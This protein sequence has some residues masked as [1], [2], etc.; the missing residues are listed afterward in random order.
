[1]NPV[2]ADSVSHAICLL[3]FPRETL[4]LPWPK[5]QPGKTP[6]IFSDTLLLCMFYN[7]FTCTI[8]PCHSSRDLHPLLLLH[9]SLPL[10]EDETEPLQ[11]IFS[12][13]A[14]VTFSLFWSPLCHKIQ[15][16]FHIHLSHNHPDLL[17]SEEFHS[18]LMTACILAYLQVL[19]MFNLPYK[20]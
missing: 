7:N 9:I 18:F 2:L 6:A 8:M 20:F 19:G 13:T 11:E 4:S 14:S 1:M 5:Y 17:L 15:T 10:K 12:L 16:Q 3:H